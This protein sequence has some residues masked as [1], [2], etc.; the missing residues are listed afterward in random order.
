VCGDG[1][2]SLGEECDDGLNDG[3]Y[4]EC[5]PGCKLGPLRRPHPAAGRRLRWWQSGG[6]RWLRSGVPERRAALSVRRGAKKGSLPG[7]SGFGCRG[8]KNRL[9]YPEMARLSPLEQVAL[10]ELA[11][12]VRQQFGERLVA[13]TLFGSRARGEGRDDSDLDVLVRLRDAT[14]ED[15]R[16]L[17]DLAFDLGLDQG[18]VISPL[19]ADVATWRHDSFLA[20]AIAREGVAL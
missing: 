5:E 16:V 2:V 6:W 19:L 10:R 11:G 20:R 1:I 3:G 9:H 15:R 8:G 17:Q 7:P 13:V 14:R 18:L 4:G 12:R